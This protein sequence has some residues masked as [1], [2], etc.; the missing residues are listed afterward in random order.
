MWPPW[1]R[2]REG[3][4]PVVEEVRRLCGAA[5]S[6]SS[7]LIS[8][9][10]NKMLCHCIIYHPCNWRNCGF[11]WFLHQ[12]LWKVNFGALCFQKLQICVQDSKP[13]QYFWTG[14][15]VPPW[16]CSCHISQAMV[17]LFSKHKARYLKKF[18]L[19]ICQLKQFWKRKIVRKGPS[20]LLT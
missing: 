1:V 9:W 4:I 15:Q 10:N 3:T 18:P 6:H 8:S 7:L 17:N 2:Y 11:D 19:Q 16:C 20:C 14:A 13:S 12:C 5:H